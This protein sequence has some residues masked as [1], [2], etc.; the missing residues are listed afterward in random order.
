[1]V[2]MIMDG[3]DELNR[4]ELD[5]FLKGN[6]SLEEVEAK[7]PY[8]WLGDNAWKDIQKL[9]GLQ[10][11][12]TGFQDNLLKNGQDWRNWYDLEAPE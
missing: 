10:E 3:N 9:D 8:P 4:V 2:T 12:W 1:M 11:A 5:F 7:K 6:T